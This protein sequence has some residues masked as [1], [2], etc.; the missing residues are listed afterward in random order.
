MAKRTT[1][2][3]TTL[4][5]HLT[6]EK[7]AR[8][9]LESLRWPNGVA[10][11]RCGG[12]DPYKLNPNPSGK[13]P[14]R[15][16]LY[17]C[18]ACKK[19]FSS[20]TG[21]VFE[22]SHVPLSKW[23]LAIHLLA[24][25]KKGMSAHQ[26]HRMLDVTYR[27][28]WF[29]FHRLRH[30]MTADGAVQL[31]GVV[32]A[33]ETYVGARRLRGTKRG[34]PGPE[35]HKAPVVALV[36]RGGQVRMFPMP[37]VTSNNLRSALREHVAPEATLMTDEFP[38]YGKLG[39]EFAKHETVNHGDGEYVRGDAHVNTAEGVFA[40]LKRGIM[41]SFHH[42]SKGHLH[43]YTTEFEFRH[44]TRMALGVDDGQRAGAIVAGAEGKRLTYRM[45]G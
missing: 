34:R 39:K 43:R 9:F 3:L 29:M 1:G 31:T 30:A 16:G 8:E 20:T 33:D 26:L 2:T 23:L 45:P 44:N 38:I 6:D 24:S 5:K 18:R 21:T 32:E 40:L 28:A 10:C 11:P 13:N 41:G 7:A 17:K 27:A 22:S 36:E 4:A 19:Q 35:S 42:V 14:A 15:Q 25:S 37:R 12:A